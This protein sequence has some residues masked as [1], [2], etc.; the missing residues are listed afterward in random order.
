MKF[1]TNILILSIALI[2][3]IGS[4]GFILEQYFCSSC[5]SE[6]NEV[7]LFEFGE[8]NHDHHNCKSHD[9]DQHDCDNHDNNHQDCTC[10]SDEHLKNTIITY[11]SLDL[12][13]IDILSPLD[14]SQIKVKNL[15]K[16]FSG[17]QNQTAL[18]NFN[19]K[20]FIKDKLKIPP[21][22]RQFI[23]SISF[24]AVNSIFRL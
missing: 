8:I 9:K 11:V 16:K 20:H 24:C 2:T 15:I 1:I 14:F 12:L 18:L 17:S 13:F 4:N 6:H 19:S 21:L 5:N 23:S 7:A 3:L 10:N 22:I